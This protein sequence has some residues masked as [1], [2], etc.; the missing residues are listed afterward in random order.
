MQIRLFCL[1]CLFGCT[2]AWAQNKDFIP[3]AESP[4]S[5][6]PTEIPGPAPELDVLLEKARQTE[7][8]SSAMSLNG[9]WLI[10]QDL[11]LLSVYDEANPDELGIILLEATKSEGFTNLKDLWQSH[12]TVG[13]LPEYRWIEPVYAEQKHDSIRIILS[14]QDE[15]GLGLHVVSIHPKG[16]QEGF[17]PLLYRDEFSNWETPCPLAIEYDAQDKSLNLKFPVATYLFEHPNA[18][19][20]LLRCPSVRGRM[21]ANELNWTILPDDCQTNQKK[22]AIIELFPSHL[23]WQKQRI[24]KAKKLAKIVGKT[25][26]ARAGEDF[27]L[28]QSET[29]LKAHILREIDDE[30][31]EAAWKAGILGEWRENE[32]HPGIPEE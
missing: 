4:L 6:Q 7:V 10:G 5:I 1:L 25:D 11:Y 17:L 24:P 26:A 32:W 3:C 23:L 13:R 20:D 16:S 19:Y 14:V 8:E 9:A 21:D 29:A 18:R 27:F 22:A 30:Q 2:F 28:F 12:Y 15:T 31:F